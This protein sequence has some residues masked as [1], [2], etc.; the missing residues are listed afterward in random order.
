MDRNSLIIG[1]VLL[2]LPAPASANGPVLCGF[3]NGDGTVALGPCPASLP[4]DLGTEQQP[5]NVVKAGEIEVAG[6]RGVTQV[7]HLPGC[8]LTIQGG[9]IVAATPTSPFQQTCP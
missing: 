5:W 7:V 3:D 4:T 8:T 9:I 6:Q 2:L 1:A